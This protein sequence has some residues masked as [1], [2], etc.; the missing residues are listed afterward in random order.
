MLRNFTKHLRQSRASHAVPRIGSNVPSLPPDIRNHLGQTLRAEYYER[1]DKPR[2][3]GDTALPLEF[4]PYL[5][6]I[7][8]QERSRRALRIREQGANAIAAALLE[9]RA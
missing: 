8:Q 5:Y 1:G 7:E 9:S 4:D 2:F 6:R 3:L